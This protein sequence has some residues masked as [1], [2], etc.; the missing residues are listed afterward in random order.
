MVQQ[1][2]V[3]KLLDEMDLAKGEANT[4]KEPAVGEEN[5][6]LAQGDESDNLNAPEDKLHEEVEAHAQ[7]THSK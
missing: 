6:K 5:N 7:A 3:R 2:R 1:Q 4:S